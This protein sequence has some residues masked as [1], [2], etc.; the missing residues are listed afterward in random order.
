M[1]FD[2]YYTIGKDILNSEE[3]YA[4]LRNGSVLTDDY[5]YSS[6]DDAVYDI[7]DGSALNKELYEEEIKKFQNDL[8]ISDLILEKDA[9][10][11]LE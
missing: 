10:R 8:R 3:G 1:G 2:H 6:Q 11:K 9:L 5:Y 7:K 4:V